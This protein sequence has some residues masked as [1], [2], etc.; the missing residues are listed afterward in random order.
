MT[1]F[2]YYYGDGT[3]NVVHLTKEQADATNKIRIIETIEDP[4][5]K[6]FFV[7]TNLNDEEMKDY[8]A[9]ADIL[10]AYLEDHD[11]YYND[12]DQPMLRPVE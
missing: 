1:T 12:T 7:K 6:Q 3:D 2:A 8:S 4:L 5:N 10:N 11:V 9:A